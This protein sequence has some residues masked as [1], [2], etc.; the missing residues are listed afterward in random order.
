[1]FVL[2][3]NNGLNRKH[4]I[5]IQKARLYT[6]IEI[7]ELECWGEVLGDDD[8]DDKAGAYWAKCWDSC[9]EYSSWINR[10]TSRASL[11]SIREEIN[12]DT[13]SIIGLYESTGLYNRDLCTKISTFR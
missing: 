12:Y 10:A 1:M 13:D 5:A 11:D 4:T 7:K 6:I 3:Q 8:I 9:S 2:I